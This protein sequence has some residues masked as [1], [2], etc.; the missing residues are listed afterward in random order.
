MRNIAQLCPVCNGSG[1]IA[2]PPPKDSTSNIWGSKT[3]HGCG[4]KG[5]IVVEQPTM[6][7]TE[8]PWAYPWWVGQDNR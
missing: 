2:I 7:Y 1:T 4:G 6:Y 3:C 8:R 5:W